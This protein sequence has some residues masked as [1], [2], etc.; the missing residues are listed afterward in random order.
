MT[1]LPHGNWHE[2]QIYLNKHHNIENVIITDGPNAPFVFLNEREIKLARQ[3][4]KQSVIGAGDCFCAF[5]AMCLAHKMSLTDAVE[6][7]WNASS[8]YIE[9]K[10]NKPIMPHELN[11]W[12]DPIRA[13]IVSVEEMRSIIGYD[14]STFVWTNGCFDFAIH[15]GHLRTLETAKKNG[16]KVIVGLNTDESV[17]ELKGATRPILT[18]GQR[19]EN[20]SHLQY[21]DFIVPIDDSTLQETIKVLKP[22]VLVKGDEYRDKHVIGS[23]HLGEWGGKIVFVP[24]VPKMSTTNNIKISN[25]AK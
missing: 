4:N 16:D 6:V 12:S 8:K 10:H 2:H 17:K 13:K 7:S 1:G 14:K 24:M 25:E 3:P 21:V 18:W 19:A 20:L 23:E 22:S 15:T 9:S 5:L 11:Q